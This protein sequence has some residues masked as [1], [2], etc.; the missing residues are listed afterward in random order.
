MKITRKGYYTI[1]RPNG[2]LLTKS[3]GTTRR[4][5]TRDDCYEYITEDAAQYTDD[6]TYIYRIIPPEYEVATDLRFIIP[7]AG[8][9]PGGAPVQNIIVQPGIGVLGLTG[10]TTYNFL[11]APPPV[12]EGSWQLATGY[13]IPRQMPMEIVHPRPESNSRARYKWAHTQFEYQIPIGIQGGAWPFKYELISGPP[14]MTVGEV[15][16]IDGEGVHSPGEWYGNVRWP[17]PSG[18]PYSCTVRVYDQG[19]PGSSIDVDWTVTVD[20]S[21]FTFLDAV[22]GTDTDGGPATHNNPIKTWVNYY[23]AD[24]DNADYDDQ[25]LVFKNG[26]YPVIGDGVS[27]NSGSLRV[28]FNTN[29]AG[30]MIAYPGHSPVLDLTTN[31]FINMGDELFVGGMTCDGATTTR[32][33]TRVFTGANPNS[34]TLLKTTWQNISDPGI[35]AKDNPNTVFF[36]GNGGG[37]YTLFKQNTWNNIRIKS[38]DAGLGGVNGALIDLYNNYYCLFEQNTINSNCNT[39]YGLWFKTTRQL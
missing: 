24:D 32:L 25:I 17:N 2:E 12:V 15:M 34:L 37:Y 10:Y 13:Y 5:V 22:N 11:T 27:E 19:D 9:A 20:D 38:G 31:H 16:D 36:A 7:R 14:G 23:Q 3:D 4:A 28:Q 21:K 18:G 26:T 8:T 6:E 39:D 33:N 1:R 35:N 30:A 29:K